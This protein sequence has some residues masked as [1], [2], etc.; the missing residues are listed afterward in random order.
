MTKIGLLMIGYQL[1]V[2]LLHKVSDFI[3]SK[4][5]V[6]F[7]NILKRFESYFCPKQATRKLEFSKASLHCHPLLQLIKN[8][9]FKL[10]TAHEQRRHKVDPNERDAHVHCH[11]EGGNNC[12]RCGNVAHETQVGFGSNPIRHQQR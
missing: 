1:H 3:I 8:F 6:K 2:P 7:G 11:S 4:G 12:H 9:M 5:R 10:L